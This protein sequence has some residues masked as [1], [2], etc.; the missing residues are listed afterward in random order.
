MT[1]SEPRLPEDHED[2]VEL[3]N[4][5]RGAYQQFAEDRGIAPLPEEPPD[6]W[7]DYGSFP[8]SEEPPAELRT[9]GPTA[10]TQEALDEAI[11]RMLRSAMTLGDAA[12][13]LNAVASLESQLERLKA[14]SLTAFEA[15]E[16]WQMCVGWQ[17]NPIRTVVVEKL[18]R[19][20]QSEQTK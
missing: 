4:L 14:D 18:R 2:F 9:V 11:G 19:L 3:R 8:R 15:A 6:M 5:S 20:S 7:T 12:T 13:I 10:P 16:A 1:A 17:V